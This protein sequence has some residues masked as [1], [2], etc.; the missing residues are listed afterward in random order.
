MEKTNAELTK[1]NIY[2]EEISYF[3]EDRAK[4]K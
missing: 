2:E 4:V 1:V 3:N